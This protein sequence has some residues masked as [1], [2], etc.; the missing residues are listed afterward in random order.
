MI[1]NADAL[2]EIRKLESE[3]VDLVVTDPPFP[4]P[5]FMKGRKTFFED[6]YAEMYRVLKPDAEF[7]INTDYRTYPLYFPILNKKSFSLS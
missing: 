3:S 6:F 5:N 4:H 2:D 7:Y 1:I